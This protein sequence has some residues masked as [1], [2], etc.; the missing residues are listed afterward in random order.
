MRA[1]STG[2]RAPNTMAA[3]AAAIEKRTRERSRVLIGAR[4]PQRAAGALER[5]LHARVTGDDRAPH[6]PLAPEVIERS[7]DGLHDRFLLAG[8]GLGERPAAAFGHDSG[9]DDREQGGEQRTGR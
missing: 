7:L 5:A 3:S 8:L 6:V 2:G 1:T 9:A 4:P